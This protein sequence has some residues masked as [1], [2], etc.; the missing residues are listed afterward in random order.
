MNHLGH[1]RSLALPERPL[2]DLGNVET[3]LALPVP[4]RR[5]GDAA[6]IAEPV[7]HAAT[8]QA[9]VTVYGFA[10]PGA[11]HSSTFRTSH[12]LRLPR[13]PTLR[14]AH[15][16]T[17][18][19]AHLTSFKAAAHEVWILASLALRLLPVVACT[20]RVLRP[21]ADEPTAIMSMK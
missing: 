20:A 1:L 12:V 8:S 10:A 13:S 5:L 9:A 17:R 11:Y 16:S 4:L 2:L 18:Q 15:T 6:P 14:H 7:G 21:H 3:R 19:P